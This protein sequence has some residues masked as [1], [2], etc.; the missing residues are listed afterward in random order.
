M[1]HGLNRAWIL[2]AI[3]F[4]NSDQRVFDGEQ[5]GRDM[6]LPNQAGDGVKKEYKHKTL[7]AYYPHLF[8]LHDY[9]H[10]AP[11]SSTTSIVSETDSIEYKRL[12]QETICAS[13]ITPDSLPPK[14]EVWGTQHEVVDRVLG[15]VAR[16]CARQGIK[17]VLVSGDKVSC[18]AL[19][20]GRPS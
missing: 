4:V 11:S 12:V 7:S 13:R 9:L 2:N 16:R 8:T 19:G 5:H 15:E 1:S 6:T 20:S 17:D 10:T 18:I 14:V 3:D